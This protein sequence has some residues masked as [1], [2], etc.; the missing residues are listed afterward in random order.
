MEM[1]TDSFL[2][3]GFVLF[4]RAHVEFQLNTYPDL[5]FWFTPAQFAGRLIMSKDS[6]HIVL[7]EM[8]V[9]NNRSLN[10]GR[11]MGDL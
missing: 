5:P 7:F 10:I 3:Y 2:M 9:P 6:S 11:C 4:S 1:K 8:E